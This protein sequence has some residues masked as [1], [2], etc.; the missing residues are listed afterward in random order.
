MINKY[1]IIAL[2]NATIGS[3]PDD[4]RIKFMK[5]FKIFIFLFF[6][7]LMQ[8]KSYAF[9]NKNIDDLAYVFMEKNKV[10]GMSIAILNKDKTLIFNYGFSNRL[11]KIP[12]TSNTIYTI[13]SFTKTFTATLAAV[14]SVDEKLNL[15]APFIKYF[16]K[17]KNH[18]NLN[19]ITSSEL[20]AHVSSFPFDFEPRPK[21]YSDLVNSLNQFKP[22]RAPGREYRYS[23]AGIG[24]MGYVL[25]NFR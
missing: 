25:Q 13:A 9:S 2:L 14:A 21:T 10:D 1:H 22:Q 12:T 7:V 20:L 15:D 18:L 5:K 4:I 8:A 17:L 11:K 3:G 23:N 19:R 6:A 16:P 24:T